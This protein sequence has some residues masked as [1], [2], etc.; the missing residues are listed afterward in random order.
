LQV[1]ESF[2]IYWPTAADKAKQNPDLPAV[3]LLPLV[4]P[5][6]KLLQQWG[7]EAIAS[8]GEELPYDP[9]WHRLKEGT[10]EP[11]DPVQ[12]SNV[13]YRI[14]DKLLHRATVMPISNRQKA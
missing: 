7:V 6:E 12:V 14:G 11:G 9:Q 4:K 3:R 2:L 8:V 1:L 10:A 13:G 5:V